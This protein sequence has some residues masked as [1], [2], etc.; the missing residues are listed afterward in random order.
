VLYPLRP[1]FRIRIEGK[2]LVPRHG[3]VILASN[4]V[5][6]IDPLFMLW[7]GERTH[8]KVRF[9]AMAELW[10]HAVMRFFLVHTKQI[11]V[12]RE[13]VSAADSLVQACGALDDGECV[14]I[15]PEG[16]IST[17]LDPLPGRTGVARLAGLSG[18]PV[19]PVGVWGGHR[20][21]P[22]GHKRTL[23]FGI[24]ITIAVG[25]PV[26]V[27]RDEDPYEATDRV[28]AGIVGAVAHARRMYTQRPRRREGDWWV[29]APESAVLRVTSRTATRDRWS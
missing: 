22:K 1:A 12:T 21:W 7:L 11:P 13:S 19:L 29:R 17:D 8:R 9:L 16:V 23:R 28:M 25:A 3:P 6:F 27:A 24:G 14:G 4:H 20:I 2:E 15:Y 10:N 26:P 5:S 18:V